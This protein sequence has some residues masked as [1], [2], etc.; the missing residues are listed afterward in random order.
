[1][2]YREQRPSRSTRA[3]VSIEH[4]PTVGIAIP[5]KSI[6]VL[7]LVAT[8]LAAGTNAGK[9][10]ASPLAPFD[11]DSTQSTY[12][13][14]MRL[15]G[16]TEVQ[17]DSLVIQVRSAVIR[18]AIPIHLGEQGIGRDIRII[19]GLGE[20][21][22]QGWTT[23]HDTEAQFIAASLSPGES[24][25]FG[26]LRFVIGPIK[27][28]SLQDRWLAASLGVTQ[29]LPGMQPGVL[30]SYACAEDN[31]LGA[32]DASRERA[33]LMRSAYSRTC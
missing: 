22:A 3:D 33:K 20:K 14:A 10:A 17:G 15:R 27:G 30:W 5:I 9:S 21:T 28:I 26:P 4:A 2:R 8:L 24:R 31:L 25:S 18:S 12:P 13:F 1:M 19:F 11:L 16:T 23:S 32:T 6:S 29:Q 7:I